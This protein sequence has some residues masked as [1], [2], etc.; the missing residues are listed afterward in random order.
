M[1]QVTALLSGGGIKAAAHLGAIEVL[2]RAGLVPG[3]YIGT[4][5]GAVIGALLAAGLTPEEVVD[6][7]R[8]LRRRDV[9]R[10]SASSVVQGVFASALLQPEPFQRTLALLLP[11]R[12]FSE[13]Q[14]PLTVTATDLETGELVLFGAGGEDAP[15]LDALYASCALPVWFPPL[16]RNGRRLADGGLRGVL[17]LR[18]AARF[19]ADVLVAVDAGPGFDAVPASGRLA[20]PALIRAHNAATNVLMAGNTELEL[21][22]WRA[23]NTR[24]TLLYLRPEVERGVTFALGHFDRYAEAGRRAAEKALAARG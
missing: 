9:L 22:L 12:R 21:S 13:L 6:R 7:V 14:L 4:S 5:L 23:T 8:R 15:L 2:C 3:R 10:F 24:P 19:P 18:L 11:V 1:T 16:E 17:P 20:P